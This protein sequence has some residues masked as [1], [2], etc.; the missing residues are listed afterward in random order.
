[1][2]GYFVDD[3]LLIMPSTDRRGVRLTGEVVSTH[4]APLALALTDQAREGEILLDLT[5]VHFLANSALEILVA[6]ARHLNPPEC[7]LVR[8][9]AEL[10]LEQRLAARGWDTIE[11]L[12]LVAP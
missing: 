2:R 10:A 4:R 5:G 7:L 3:L 6:F 11:T 12:R 8:A 1:M 9:K